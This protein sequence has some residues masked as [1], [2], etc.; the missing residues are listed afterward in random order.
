MNKYETRFYASPTANAGDAENS[1]HAKPAS[2]PPSLPP[3]VALEPM[4]LPWLARKA[5]IS[6]ALSR[7]MWLKAERQ[8]RDHAAFGSP[9]Y[10]K[11][12]I[13]NL[14]RELA[15]SSRSGAAGL[16]WLKQGRASIDGAKLGIGFATDVDILPGKSR[17][18]LHYDQAADISPPA[19]KV[20]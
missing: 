13:E 20:S 14:L 6:D 11:L 4:L 15:D 3:Y 19:A 10:F 18:R 7:A 1:N 5:G 9:G 8:A 2:L 12:A 17:Y 16:L